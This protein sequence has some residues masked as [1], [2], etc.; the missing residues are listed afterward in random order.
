MTEETVSVVR[1]QN[2][3]IYA[4]QKRRVGNKGG[5][6]KAV[7]YISRYSHFFYYIFPKTVKG[8]KDGF[9]PECDTLGK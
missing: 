5:G 3:R 1:V 9:D 6:S 8:Q 7:S 4:R 2:L